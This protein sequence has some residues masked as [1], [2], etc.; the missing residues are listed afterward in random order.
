MSDAIHRNGQL[1]RFVL[2]VVSGFFIAAASAQTESLEEYSPAELEQLVGPVALYP[3]DLIAIVLP[4]SSYPLQI[5]EAARY[6][7]AHEVSPDLQPDD[8]WDDAVVA[9]LNYPEVIDLLNQD[10]DWTWNLGEAVVNQQAD[11]L[12]AIQSFRGRAVT[13]GNFKTDDRQ[14][15]SETGDVIEVTPVEQEVIYVPYY[16]PSRVI[17]YQSDPVFHYYPRR[18]PLYYYPYPAHYPFSS[19]FF[20]GVTTA[21]TIGWFTD[22]VHFHYFGHSSHP[23]Y[24]RTYAGH[25]RSRHARRVRHRHVSGSRSHRVGNRFVSSRHRFGNAWQPTHRR[26]DRP[27]RHDRQRRRAVPDRR[28]DSES[29]VR[30]RGRRTGVAPGTQARNSFTNRGNRRRQADGARSGKRAVVPDRR[31]GNRSPTGVA[32][33][34][35]TPIRVARSD[36]PPRNDTAPRRNVETRAPS[37]SEPRRSTGRSNGAAPER[38]RGASRSRGES[39]R[40]RA[41]SSRRANGRSGGGTRMRSGSRR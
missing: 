35:R 3:D 12:A 41:P 38:N 6:L 5:V 33:G 18:Y 32:R 28:R 29:N 31:V 14:I 15:V 13:A 25:Y 21:Y 27:R 2:A 4:A 23:F 9:L 1:R 37:R 30:N 11:V 22:R 26:G 10:L 17:V 40:A 19:G 39:N 16:E 24:G 20:W 8:D 36:S 7:E 34:G